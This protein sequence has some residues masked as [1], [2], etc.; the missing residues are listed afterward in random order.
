MAEDGNDS[1]VHKNCAAC[2]R[3]DE[4][5]DMVACDMCRLWFHFTCV[6]VDATVKNRSWC[7]RT[8]EPLSQVNPDCHGKQQQSKEDANPIGAVGASEVEKSTKTK[9]GKQSGTT[10]KSSSQRVTVLVP[11]KRV[12]RSKAGSKGTRDSRKTAPDRSVGSSMR[13]QLALELDVLEERQ[14]VEEEELAN[15]REMMEQQLQ[16]E[17]EIR[18]KE[19]AMEARKLAEEKAFMQRK[20][21][22]EREFRNQQLALKRHSLE[23]KAKLIRQMSECSSR[24]SASADESASREKVSEWLQ[25]VDQQTEGALSTSANKTA[26]A[27]LNKRIVFSCETA[28]TVQQQLVQDARIENMTSSHPGDIEAV[29][30]TVQNQACRY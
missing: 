7:C 12:T 20:L 2:T 21:E 18:Q 15:N 24:T 10:L 9:T 14:R 27:D 8:C 11:G 26:K 3:P 17:Q 6:Q 29:V 19:L 25:G 5:S 28:K 13:A 4:V 16:H 1:Q 22:K 30:G 23:E